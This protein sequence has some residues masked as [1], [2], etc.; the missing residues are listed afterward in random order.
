M[1][2][3]ALSGTAEITTGDSAASRQQHAL[4]GLAEVKTGDR[5]HLLPAA[6]L[7]VTP[8]VSPG[9]RPGFQT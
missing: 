9:T 3:Q 5:K 7:T 1:A 8:A 4:T 2:H 6:N